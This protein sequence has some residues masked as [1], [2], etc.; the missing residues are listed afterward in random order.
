MG[1]RVIPDC[2]ELFKEIE[3]LMANRFIPVLIGCEV[4]ALSGSERAL[5]ALPVRFGGLDLKNPVKTLSS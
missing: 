5:M 4:S 1:A 2:N 3:Q